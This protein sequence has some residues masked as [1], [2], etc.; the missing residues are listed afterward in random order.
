MWASYKG[1]YEVVQEL[2][3]READPNVKAEVSLFIQVICLYTYF[4]A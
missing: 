1:R 3:D 4:K 2:L